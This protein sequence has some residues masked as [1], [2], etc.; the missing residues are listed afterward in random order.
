MD[1]LITLIFTGLRAIIENYVILNQLD[2]PTR[3][4]SPLQRR[5]H[6][7]INILRCGLVILLA[8]MAVTVFF[9]IIDILIS[10]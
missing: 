1:K 5:I 4:R 8:G 7:T 10:K 9:I 6:F 3:I 2:E